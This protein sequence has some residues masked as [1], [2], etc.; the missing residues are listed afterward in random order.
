[1]FTAIVVAAK[2]VDDKYYN[3]SYYTKVGGIPLQTLNVQEET[4]MQLI[5]YHCTANPDVFN[6]YLERL[7]KFNATITQEDTEKLQSKFTQ[8]APIT[9]QT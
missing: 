6:S 3:N 9:Q 1:M 7:E 8:A 4:F 2:F 5:N